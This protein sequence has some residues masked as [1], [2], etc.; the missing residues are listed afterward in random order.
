[1]FFKQNLKTN[2]AAVKWYREILTPD[3]K[4]KVLI[5]D[6]DAHRK[7]CRS[8]PPEK[9]IKFLETNADALKKKRESFSPEDKDLFAKNHTAEQ[10]KYC[11]SLSSDQKAQL[12]KTDAAD[13]KNI[14]CLSLLNKK[15]KLSQ[16]MRL[17]T[18]NNMNRFPQR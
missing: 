10:H 1:M 6:T 3:K 14:E 2:S 7:Q 15:V 16:S 12:L 8:F 4:E 9:K 11:K 17:P 13:H 18:K 5:N